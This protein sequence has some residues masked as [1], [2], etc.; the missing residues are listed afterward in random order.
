MSPHCCCCYTL[1]VFAECGSVEVEL[2]LERALK[3]KFKITVNMLFYSQSFCSA[4]VK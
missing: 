1:A 4:I 3:I 2:P